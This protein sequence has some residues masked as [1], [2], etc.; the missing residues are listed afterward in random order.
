MNRSLRAAATAVLVTAALTAAPPPA[1]ALDPP[2]G[3]ADVL[4]LHGV[5]SAALPSGDGDVNPITVF[6]DQGAWHA[7]ALPGA[8]D[9]AQYGGF[10]GPLYIAQEYP[11]WLSRSF[12]RIQLSESGRTLDLAA[13]GTP[14]FVSLPG[15]LSERYDLGGGLRLTLDLRFADDRTALVR[16]GLENDGPA[17]RTLGVGWTGELLRPADEPMRSAPAL[18]ATGQGV[19]VSFARVR[20]TW[21]YLTDGTE[22]FEVTHDAP[23]TST[24]TGD[25][26]RTDL[27][28]PVR[29]APGAHRS[30]DWAE[31]YTFTADEAARARASVR[32]LL[33][34]P[35]AAVEAGERRWRGY[36]AGATAGVPAD[37]RRTAVKAV[38]TLVTNWR[39]AA[40]ALRHDGITPSISDKWFAGGFWSWDTWKQAVGTSRFDAP[41]AQS[42][43]RAMFDYQVQPDD[44]ERP[45][46]AGMIPDCLFYNDPAH[47]GGNWNERNSKPPLAAW[48]VWQVYLAGHDLGFLRELYPKLVAYQQWWSR[49]RDHDGNGLAE[50][51][52]TLD[53]AN[54]DAESTRQAA[55]W[56]SGMDNA[57]RFDAQAGAATVANRSAAGAPLGY[58]L[59]QESVDLNSYLSADRGYLAQ[60]AGRLGLT[61]E[62]A[63]WRASAAALAAQVRGR[64]YDPATGWFYDTALGTGTPLVARGRG[65]EGAIPL[66]TG[67]A[68]REQAAAVRGK[69]VDPGEFATPLP[70]PTVAASSPAF[71]AT[72]YWRGAVWLDQAYFALTGLQRYGYR[73]DA[74]ALTD[75]LLAG[76]Q[77]LTGDQP[78]HENYDPLT[79]RALNSSNFSWSAALLLPLLAG[80]EGVDAGGDGGGDG[81]A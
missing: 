35:Q 80:D 49:N 65:I 8:G 27:T 7:Y 39:S 70:F 12:S 46:D 67:V 9:R 18:A 41:L 37:R 11:W 5:P 31:S 76:A 4:D 54:A 21:D 44:P 19:A 2:G 77:G 14:V 3:Y 74:R 26:Y 66:W 22:R 47:G 32:T 29:L 10:S 43:I 58:S 1:L 69:L 52:A 25:S 40:G 73:A 38:E 28:A 64:M 34:H 60:I 20:S 68:S 16:A 72:G 71:D 56:E 30:I 33:R 6:A 24:V 17:A 51:G 81:G 53:P 50:Y 59:D 45:Q 75:R 57:P 61:A 23:V 13:G 63:R 42:Q 78:I 55:A 48:S 36:L 79:G 15:A 62:A